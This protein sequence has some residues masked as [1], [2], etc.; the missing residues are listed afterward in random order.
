[1]TTIRVEATIP[2]EICETSYIEVDKSIT[3]SVP[4]GCIDTYKAAEY[5]SEFTNIQDFSNVESVVS[6]NTIKVSTHN[7]S[8]VING[9]TDNAVANIYS[10]QGMLIHTTT[11]KNIG[12][13]T[14]P[15]G[16]Y[17]LQVEGTTHKVVL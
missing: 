6:D 10:M 14:L 5:W 15:H 16:A 12:K 8:I 1:L 13:I 11:A 7:G 4:V 2:A 17:I 9:T 3:L